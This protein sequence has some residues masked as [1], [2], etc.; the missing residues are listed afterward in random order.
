M[1]RK[2]FIFVVSM[3]ESE[4]DSGDRPRLLKL[5]KGLSFQELLD[6][7]LV[8]DLWL[9][10]FHAFRKVRVYKAWLDDNKILLLTF[11]F[12]AFFMSVAF[13]EFFIPIHWC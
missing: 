1:D 10:V 3:A 5:I 8:L 13:M 2:K 11:F 12:F 6:V 9:G 4:K 7:L